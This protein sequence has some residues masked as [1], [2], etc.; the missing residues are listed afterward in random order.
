MHPSARISA[1]IEILEDLETRRRPASDALK[2]WGLSHRFAGSKDRAAIASLV[3]DALRRRAGARYLMQSEAPRAEMIGALALARDMT[4]DEVESHF[5]GVGHAPAPLTDEERAH[6]RAKNLADAPDWVLGD[7]PEWLAPHFA[8]A[9]G[10]EAVAEGRALAARAPLDLRVNALK[11]TRPEML[12]EL[13]HLGVQTCRF[14]PFGLRIAQGAAGRG[15]ALDAE[16]AYA[17]GMVEIQDEGSQVAAALC[18]AA[19][20]EK[21]LDLCAGGGGKTLALAAAMDNQGELFA[22]DSDGRRLTPI[23]PRL[24]R[25]GVKNVT[26]RAPRGKADPVA[27]LE[28]ACDL[29]VIDAPCT[30]VGTWRRNPD[31]KWRTRPGA[32]EQRQAGQDEVL[33]RGARHV[34]PGGR[35]VYVTCSL[36]REENEDRLAAF[37]GENADFSCENAAETLSRAGLEGLD[38]AASPHGPGLRLTPARHDVDGFFVALLQRNG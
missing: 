22:T 19:P 34:R 8:R 17:R 27:D 12:A 35:L 2:D 4:A 11:A 21:V 24:E 23:F 7:Y 6:L 13:A 3:Y 29:V 38:G 25:A 33:R 14:A 31:A 10:D 16:P 1:A 32:L 9:F 20:G 36:L 26:V 5:S 15:A 28:G 18:R 30:G 37:L